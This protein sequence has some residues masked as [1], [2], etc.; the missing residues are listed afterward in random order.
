M[1]K[2]LK[3]IRCYAIYDKPRS[4]M[5]VDDRCEMYRT[6][7]DA[8]KD[9]KDAGIEEGVHIVPGHFVPDHSN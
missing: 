7:R 6:R 8:E 9:I 5:V 4:M 1:T 2:P 3:K